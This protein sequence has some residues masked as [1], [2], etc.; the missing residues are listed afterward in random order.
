M[1]YRPIEGA[2][3]IQRHS[4]LSNWRTAYSDR[5]VRTS[6]CQ[7][8]AK[9]EAQ[10]GEITNFDYRPGSEKIHGNQNGELKVVGCFELGGKNKLNMVRMWAV[11]L[12]HL[13]G[14]SSKAKVG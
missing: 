13:T 6:R 3:H 4:H 7:A 12:Y 10:R 5:E 11:P 9:L 1:P 2:N 8:T 14:R